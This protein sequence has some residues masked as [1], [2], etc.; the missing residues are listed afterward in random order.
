MK[1]YISILKK[2]KLFS[3]LSGS[4]IS[5]MLNCLDAKLNSYK[6]GEYVFRQGERLS[7]ITVLV[8]GKLLIQNDDYWGN[9]AIVNDIAVGEMF[10]EA[11][12]APESG[13]ILND[14]I[15]VEDSEVIFF[16]VKRIIVY[17]M[18]ETKEMK[19]QREREEQEERQ[20][21]LLRWRN[22]KEEVERKINELSGKQVKEIIFDTEINKW[23]IS[24]NEFGSK[25][26]QKKDVIVLVEDENKNLFGGYIGN[27][28]VIGQN[29]KDDSCYVFSLRKNGVFNPKKYQ[30]IND[31]AKSYR[32]GNNSHHI[33]M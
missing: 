20:S 19:Q 10:G 24:G 27:E 25:I 28:I 17:E 12:V 14:V 18:E 6:K 1:N 16:D 23:T 9:R 7:H 5:S 29:V 8:E 21:D 15:A 32:I 3:G 31:E 13:A 11:Y 33:F 26:N 4:D 30:R 22:E 2:T